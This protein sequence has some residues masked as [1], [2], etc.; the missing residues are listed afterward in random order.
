M[1][2]TLFLSGI[3]KGKVKNLKISHYPG[4]SHSVLIS[5]GHF[6]LHFLHF[7]NLKHVK[8]QYYSKKR[9]PIKSLEKNV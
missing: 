3:S 7:T 5:L 2:E 1:G 8:Q 4:I 9:Y 6:E